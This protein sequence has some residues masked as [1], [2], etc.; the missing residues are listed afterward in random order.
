MGRDIGASRQCGGWGMG[1]SGQCGEGY[2]GIRAMWGVWGHQGNVG[3]DIGAIGAIWGRGVGYL[4]RRLL[5][6]VDDIC[7]F[8]FC[9]SPCQQIRGQVVA[10]GHCYNGQCIKSANLS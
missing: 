1:A 2:R 10:F 6:K 4:F 5:R 3:R 8:F 7:F 9:T